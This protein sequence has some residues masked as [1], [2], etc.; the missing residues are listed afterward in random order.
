MCGVTVAAAAV[1][2][3]FKCVSKASQVL[4]LDTFPLRQFVS[5]EAL[6]FHRWYR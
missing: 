1:K 4:V 2:F 3:N 5:V 6:G